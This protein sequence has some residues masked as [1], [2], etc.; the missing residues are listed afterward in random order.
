M[1]LLYDASILSYGACQNDS[2]SGIYFTALN[3]LRELI[4]REDIEIVLYCENRYYR[5]LLKTL[6]FEFPNI[7]FDIRTSSKYTI[8]DELYDEIQVLKTFAKNNKI[9]DFIVSK[10]NGNTWTLVPMLIPLF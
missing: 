5:N 4:I 3:I 8:K 2:R 7:K 1:K 6:A 9:L 10:F